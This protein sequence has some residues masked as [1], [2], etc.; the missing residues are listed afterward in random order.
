MAE[1][2]S[3]LARQTL[4]TFLKL[5]HHFRTTNRQISEHGV[6]PRMF[7][8][9]RFIH[10]QGAVTVGDVQEYLYRSPSTASTF[11]SKLEDR[12]LVTRTRSLEDNRVVI[13]ELTGEGR[14]IA[15]ETPLQGIPL[16]RRKLSGLSRERLERINDA[17]GDILDLMEV[18]GDE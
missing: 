6:H 11:I 14:R 13:V 8:V 9:L 5:Y 18:D 12:G 2:E 17:L 4:D 16:L 1:Y 3:G 15:T 10:E 7:S